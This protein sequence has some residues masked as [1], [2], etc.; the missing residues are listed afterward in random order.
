MR[1]PPASGPA[2]TL[3]CLLGTAAPP[4]QVSVSWSFSTGLDVR[5]AGSER[6]RSLVKVTQPALGELKP[7][8][9]LSYPH[10]CSSC[11]TMMCC[12]TSLF[13]YCAFFV[14]IIFFLNS[15]PLLSS[16]VRNW[17]LGTESALQKSNR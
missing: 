14:S 4:A 2:G 6:E 13:V 11:H 8:S 3:P 17:N 9:G 5:N 10:L 15:P 7:V 12:V 16:F 1:G